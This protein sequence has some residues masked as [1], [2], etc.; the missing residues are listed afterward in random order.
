M[1]MKRTEN[2]NSPQNGLTYIP[3]VPLSHN[4]LQIT[5]NSMESECLPFYLDQH[6]ILACNTL[7]ITQNST[8]SECL[9]FYI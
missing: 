1:H 4:A 8:E 6:V 9:P 2:I 5:Q 7:Q 3:P